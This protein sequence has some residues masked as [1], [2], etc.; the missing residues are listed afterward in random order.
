[1]VKRHVFSVER[2]CPSTNAGKVM[3]RGDQVL[4]VA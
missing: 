2:Y 1:M 3:E 4:S